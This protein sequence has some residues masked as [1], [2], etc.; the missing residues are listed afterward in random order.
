MTHTNTVV[1]ER[2]CGNKIARLGTKLVNVFMGN[3]T[4]SFGYTFYQIEIT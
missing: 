1:K 3:K 4:I 2:E